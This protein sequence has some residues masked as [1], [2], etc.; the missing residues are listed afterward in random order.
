MSVSETR[1]EP[2]SARSTGRGARSAA[3]LAGAT[4]R[5]CS[6]PAGLSVWYGPRLALKDITIDIPATRSPR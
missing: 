5:S 2:R 4:T 3:D 6:P 1:A